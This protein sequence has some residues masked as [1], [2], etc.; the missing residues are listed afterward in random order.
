M[1]GDRVRIVTDRPEDLGGLSIERCPPVPA[2][3]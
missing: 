3:G 2:T 1:D